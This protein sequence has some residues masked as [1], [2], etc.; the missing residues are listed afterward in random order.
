M[1][2]KEKEIMEAAKVASKN[3]EV[4][5]TFSPKSATFHY[6]FIKGFK[7]GFNLGAKE[8]KCDDTKLTE[9]FFIGSKSFVE[10]KFNLS[11]YYHPL[12]TQFHIDTTDYKNGCPVYHI[13]EET[14]IV[15][16]TVGD[17]KSF[18][19]LLQITLP[20]IPQPK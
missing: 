17:I 12:A 18:Y 7:A 13:G 16:K 10:S 8:P 19:A 14:D 20:S 6:G 9:D 4:D 5:E 3:C 1:D 15:L 11:N 2:N